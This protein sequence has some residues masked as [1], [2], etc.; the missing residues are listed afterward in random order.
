MNDSLFIY[1]YLDRRVGED[2]TPSG[3]DVL[4]HGLTESVRLVPVEEG[5]LQTIILVQEAVHGS[6]YDRH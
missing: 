2:L 4:L 5:H 1:V 6:Q 3:L